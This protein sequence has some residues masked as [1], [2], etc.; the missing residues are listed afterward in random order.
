LEGPSQELTRRWG[1]VTICKASKL[2]HKYGIQTHATLL[3]KERKEVIWGDRGRSKRTQSR[4]NNL[5][6][7][8]EHG[9]NLELRGKHRRKLILAVRIHVNSFSTN[10]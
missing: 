6:K 9:L 4:E 10:L 2:D 1:R 5:K 8:R 7:R 3:R